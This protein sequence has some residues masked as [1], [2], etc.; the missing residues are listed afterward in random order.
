MS[1]KT[2]KKYI[3]TLL[4]GIF[5]PDDGSEKDPLYQA[6]SIAEDN[7]EIFRNEYDGD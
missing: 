5:I 6:L 2:R 7:R 1:E 3:K 4:D